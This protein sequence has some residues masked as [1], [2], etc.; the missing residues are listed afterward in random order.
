MRTFF[1]VL[2]ILLALHISIGNA[3]CQDDPSLLLDDLDIM[4]EMKAETDESKLQEFLNVKVSASSKKE[5]TT[6]ETP[7]I[8]TVITADEIRRSSASDLMEVLEMVPGFDF[9]HD[10]DFMIGVGLRGNWSNDGKVLLLVDGI[11]FND[12]LY[13]NIPF[14]NH[15]PVD[16]IERIEVIRGPG[17]AIYGGTAEYG[18]ISII[19]KGGNGFE[20]INVYGEYGMLENATGRS[21]IGLQ[22]G[23]SFGKGIYGDISFHKGT[24]LL[25]DQNYQDLYYEYDEVNLKDLSG[26]N[27]TNL[28]IGLNI[29]GIQIR[30]LYDFYKFNMPDYTNDFSNLAFDLKYD[31]KINDKFTFVPRFTHIQQEPWRGTDLESG[32]IE[33][34]ILAKRTKFNLTTIYDIS[35]K[36]N[37]IFGAEGYQDYA[38]SSL[39]DDN[40][41]EGIENVK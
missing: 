18:V 11:E 12:L 40:F 24:H 22:M 9:G 30:T 21:N 19:T 2:F 10:V 38:K 33:Y 16:Q 25:S 34:N 14:G 32:E 39:D 6:R 31:Y 27:T 41:G 7:G 29:K 20:G 17:S 1:K 26:T 4:R 15:F 35:R 8:V 3:Y 28:N 5:L 23:K 36:F 37:L 13:Q